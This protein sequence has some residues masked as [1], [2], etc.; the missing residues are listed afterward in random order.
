MPPPLGDYSKS[1]GCTFFPRRFESRYSYDLCQRYLLKL[2]MRFWSD[3]IWS[4]VIIV[5]THL[6]ERFFI[7]ARASIHTVIPLHTL[8]LRYE[9]SRCLK[10]GHFLMHKLG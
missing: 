2:S 3:F 10:I 7:S 1:L 9:A 4:I 8:K 6:S 5:M